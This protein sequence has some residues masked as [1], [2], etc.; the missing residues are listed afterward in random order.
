MNLMSL[1]LLRSYCQTRPSN[2]RTLRRCLKARVGMTKRG[3]A[4][5][6]LAR[7]WTPSS[8]GAR[9]LS[10][11]RGASNERAGGRHV[12]RVSR[13]PSTS[14][15]LFLPWA[16]ARSWIPSARSSLSISSAIHGRHNSTG[17]RAALTF[18][19]VRTPIFPRPRLRSLAK[20]GNA[21]LHA[22]ART[23]FH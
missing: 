15:G 21:S 5:A 4:C 20:R 18:T 12:E 1:V 14:P 7:A 10:F 19:R 6:S 8:P 2:G 23:T 17:L 11:I 3:G 13:A 16:P 9:R 22:N